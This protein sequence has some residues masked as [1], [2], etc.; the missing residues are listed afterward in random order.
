MLKSQMRWQIQEL[1]HDDLNKIKNFEIHPIIAKILLQRGINTKTD[2]E[3]FFNI[4]NTLLYDPFLMGGME[5]AVKRIHSAILKKEKILIYGD[6]DADGV[7]STAVLYK[8]LKMLGADFAYYIPNR[9]TEGYGLNNEAV[10]EAKKRN[11]N[12]IVTVDTG[13]TAIEEAK[14]AKDLDLCLIITDHHEPPQELPDA[15]AIINPKKPD[16]T[17]PYKYLA[18][19]GVAF[20][21]AHALLGRIPNE[22]LDLAA[23]GTIADLVPLTD[24][25]RVIA[26]LGLNRIRKTNNPGLKVMLEETG[27]TGKELTSG[28]VGFIIAPRINASGRLDTAKNA[29]RLFI[30]EDPQEAKQLV[31]QLDDINQE[32]QNLVELITDEAVKIIETNNIDQDKV[33]VLAN[34]NWNEGVIGIVASK[35]SGKY[36]RPAI[37]LNI[38][39]ETRIAKGSARSIEGYNIYRALAL[40]DKILLNF[41]GHPMAAGLSIKEEDIPLLREKL[42][43]LADEWLTDDDLMPIEKIETVCNL[44]DINI[45]LINQIEKMQP[46]GIGNPS[47]KFLIEKA[48]VLDIRAIGNNN[49][50]L[51]I[52]LKDQNQLLESIAFGKGKL[53]KDI[54][55]YSDIQLLGELSINKWKGRIK[56]QIIIRDLKIETLQVFDWRN[57][58]LFEGLKEVEIIDTILLFKEKNKTFEEFIKTGYLSTM[59]GQTTLAYNNEMVK[60]L[61]LIH[62]PS[63]I[64]EVKQ[65]FKIYSNIERIYCVFEQDTVDSKGYPV[66]RDLYKKVYTSL[67]EK[68][69]FKNRKE[70]ETYVNKLE[71]S[72]EIIH[73]ILD[74]FIELGFIIIE[75]EKIIFNSEPEKKELSESELYRKFSEQEEIRQLFFN[76]NHQTLKNWFLDQI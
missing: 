22:L 45:E 36:Y 9:F 70:A 20:K 69:S 25:N 10:I 66:D 75:G 18:G 34:E 17:Y 8:T 31:K 59:Y 56:P 41:G 64:E 37:I 1:N 46:F 43:K 62:L 61:V 39:T 58:N 32:R 51:K 52:N 23:I 4:D 19:V 40:V 11:F 24:E 35:I 26:A 65:I 55:N 13:I 49:Q 30:T 73:F 68:E 60:N 54:A 38:D 47:P 48:Q 76:S 28:H 50:H 42:N 72:S 29:V 2:I 57:K 71:L 21:L 5:K 6:Y 74:V 53:L 67:K 3:R 14:L 44:N 63:S 16:E 33:I 12:L 7:T 15:F 27:L